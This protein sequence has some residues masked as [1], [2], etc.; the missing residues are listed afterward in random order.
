MY[1]DDKQTIKIPHPDSLL[2]YLDTYNLRVTDGIVSKFYE[3][4]THL[5]P[6]KVYDTVGDDYRRQLEEKTFILA[7]DK[8]PTGLQ[9][10]KK[11]ITSMLDNILQVIP[12]DR[13]SDFIHII[14]YNEKYVIIDMEYISEH[15]TTH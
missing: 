1:Q 13:Y 5:I 3:N 15:N 9:R 11:I 14:D 2:L 12:D 4:V 6:S 7:L 10:V 8:T